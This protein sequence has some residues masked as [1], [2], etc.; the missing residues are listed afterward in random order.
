MSRHVGWANKVF[1]YRKS[2]RCTLKATRD[3]GA[4][5]IMIAKAEE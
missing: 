4:L 5:K 2:D 1:V 3:L